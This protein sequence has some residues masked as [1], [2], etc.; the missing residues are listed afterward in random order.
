M[1]LKYEIIILSTLVG[2]LFIAAELLSRFFT[3][4]PT[5]NVFESLSFLFEPLLSGDELYQYLIILL[6]CLAFGVILAR[7]MSHTLK[8]KEAVAQISLEKN[9]IL[10]FTPEIIIY[11]TNE[12]IIEW[13]SRSIF[14]ETGLGES[15][16]IGKSMMNLIK[17]FFSEEAVNKILIDHLETDR[18]DFEVKSLKGKYWRINSNVARN[19]AGDI[20]GHVLLAIDITENK[21]NEE[22]KQTYYKHLESN[23]EQFATAIDNIRNP[24][25]SIVLLAEISDDQK[26]AQKIVTQCGSIEERIAVLDENWK[27]TEEIRNFLKKYE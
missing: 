24:L 26:T 25:S 12:Y 13:V 22:I 21:Q 19:K 17:K 1:K 10:D 5:G 15:E 14:T 6:F 4:D 2:V 9:M 27:N 7:L 20:V 11:M 16:I 18:F 8:V 3:G 23:I